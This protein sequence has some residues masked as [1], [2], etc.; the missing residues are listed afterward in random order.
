[1]KELKKEFWKYIMFAVMGMIGSSGT[2]LADTFF[3][4][5]RLGS[6]GLAALNIA[7]A[8]FGLI[9]G[10]GMMIGIGGASHYT[11]FKSQTR[12]CEANQ[13]FTLSFAMALGIGVLFFLTGLYGS[14]WLAQCLG[15][16]QEILS[17]CTT[18][19]RTILMFAPC[20]L[21]NHLFMSFIRNDGAPQLSMCMMIVGSFTNIILDYLFMYPFHMG[22]LGA[23]LATGLAPTISVLIAMIYILLKRNGFH[24]T[25]VP[26]HLSQLKTILEPGLSS[27]INEF[28]SGIVLVVFNFLI[29]KFAGNIGVA[30]YGIVANL[31]LIV[32]AI[33][34][35]VSQG[36]QPLLSRAYGQ[37]QDQEIQ[38]L[39]QKGRYIVSAI[40][41]FVL[42][43]AYLLSSHLVALFNHENHQTLQL[44]ANEGLRYYFIGFL[45]LGYNYLTISLLSTTNQVSSAFSLSL[46]RGCI[47]I[48]IVACLFAFLWGLKGIWLAFPFVELMTMMIGKFMFS[49]Q[50]FLKIS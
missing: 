3:V 39:Y 17:L 40:G 23:A 14:S 46:L 26:F 18:Y 38:Y 32:L 2:I 27:F 22:I 1:M 13:T 47:G 11:V 44:L 30:A 33:F 34:N 5:H 45:F 12:H 20:F 15:A 31:A 41:I 48:I 6:N 10:L 42:C 43:I 4:S 9:N 19:L 37:S 24:F 28:S 8:I 25:T 16:N 36:I 29:L 7:I 49:A 50:H 35:G 21:L